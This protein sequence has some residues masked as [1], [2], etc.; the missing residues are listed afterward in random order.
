MAADKITVIDAAGDSY[1]FMI[2]DAPFT[3]EFGIWNFWSTAYSNNSSHLPAVGVI[4][5]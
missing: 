3:L 4:T 5:T 2:E 1:S